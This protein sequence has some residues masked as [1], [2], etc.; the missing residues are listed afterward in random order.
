[1]R[2]IT[3]DDFSG[4]ILEST[5]PNDFQSNQW[6]T[7]KGII[8]NNEGLFESQWP[9]QTIGLS[10][11][12]FH[13]VYPLRSSAG[14]FLIGIKT[15]GTLWW[16]AAPAASATYTTCNA[17]SWTQLTTAENYDKNGISKES[18]VSNTD[19]KFV[20]SLPLS[21]YKFATTPSNSSPTNAARDT[22][23]G[24]QVEVAT[25]VLLHSTTMNGSSNN[26]TQQAVVAYVDTSTPAVRAVIFPNYRRTPFADPVNGTYI[27]A[28]VDQT[29]TILPYPSFLDDTPSRKFHPYTYVDINSTLLPGYGIIPR[30]NVGSVKGNLLILGDIEWRSDRNTIAPRPVQGY[31]TSVDITTGASDVSDFYV[32]TREALFPATMPKV[33][34]VVYNE[35]PGILFMKGDDPKVTASVT[36]CGAAGGVATITTGLAAHGFTTGDNVILVSVHPSLNGTYTITG[37]PT[38]TTFT[39]ATSAIV[40]ATTLLST[41]RAYAYD[42]RCSVG[43]YAVIPDTWSRMYISASV[44]KTRVK[45]VSN[46]NTSMHVL[47]DDNTGPHRGSIYFSTG[48]EIDRFDPRGVLNIG[49][50]DVSIAGVHTLGDDVIVITTAGTELD[51]VF[52][53]SGYLSRVIQYGAPSNPGAIKVNLLRGG[54]G[55]PRR[56]TST[57][58]NYSTVWAEAGAIVFI[59]RLGGVWYT[60]GVICDRFD[61]E[62]PRKPAI[63]TEDD[64]VA[65]FG[66]H[67]FVWRD[68]RLLCFTLLSTQSGRS[69]SGCWTEVN[70]SKGSTPFAVKSVVGGRD[71]VFFVETT[72]G[73]VMRMCPAAPASERA[74]VDNVPLDITV[75]TATLGD[76]SNHKR[77][78][79]HRFGMTFST[80]SSCTVKTVAVQSTA[81]I[82]ITGPVSLPDVQ[83]TST[84]NRT[85]S[86]PSILGEFVVNAGIGPQAECSATVVFNGYVQLQSASFWVTGQTTRSGDQ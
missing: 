29:S 11:T 58:K 78:N 31:L 36:A 16:A 12:G 26:H 65:E 84:L 57:H 37:T 50:T 86:A 27:R 3:I 43:R 68:G 5:S 14:T 23:T 46:L 1:M 48:G 59:D 34:R 8:P 69:G 25:A 72:T 2:K 39:V 28:R 77:T 66:S 44:S 82:N 7:L 83:Y 74:R 13:A 67:L 18:I 38:A 47:N 52:K 4:G 22:Y 24:S 80:P 85:Y 33:G 63:A 71:E 79:W 42:L 40:A 62:G 15:N 32:T 9:I 35:G 53:I 49:K 55:A 20:T 41:G 30:A 51:G 45:A 76:V 17:V 73:N 6:A 60:N 81:A 64:H 19:Y 56:T 10:A 70:L 61:R 54:I 75:S 21:V